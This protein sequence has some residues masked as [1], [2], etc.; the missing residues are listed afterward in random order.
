[1]LMWG[2]VNVIASISRWGCDEDAAAHVTLQALDAESVEP[3]AVCWN[4][5]SDFGMAALTAEVSFCLVHASPVQ[6]ALLA[7][8]WQ[9]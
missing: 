3:S 8:T 1:M 2:S 4:A 9:C 7:G 6:A 5:H